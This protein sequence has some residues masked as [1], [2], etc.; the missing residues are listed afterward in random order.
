MPSPAR[1]RSTIAAVTD[2][3]PDLKEVALVL[4]V[5]DAV[6]RTADPMAIVLALDTSGSMLAKDGSGTTAIVAAV[7]LVWSAA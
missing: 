7:P 5:I 1:V 3:P 6:A 4:A 2:P